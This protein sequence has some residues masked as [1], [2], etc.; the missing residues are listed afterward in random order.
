[1]R[2]S[3]I[4][5]INNRNWLRHQRNAEKY[6]EDRFE[7]AKVS[8]NAGTYLCNYVYYNFLKKMKG[9]ALCIHL[10]SKEVN[11]IK[12]IDTIK[13]IIDEI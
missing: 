12:I 10:P 5:G 1:M 4:A 3:S 13:Q 6:Q 8:F 11:Y 9:N 7:D 2:W